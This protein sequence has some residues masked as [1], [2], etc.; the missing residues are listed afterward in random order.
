MRHRFGRALLALALT[1]TACIGCNDRNDGDVAVEDVAPGIRNARR[2]LQKNWDQ[3]LADLQK[4]QVHPQP[5]AHFFTL[6]SPGAGLVHREALQSFY[7][8]N[9]ANPIFTDGHGRPN[10]RARALIEQARDAERHALRPEKYIRPTLPRQIQQHDEL[11]Y[12]WAQIRTP[13]LSD[14]DWVVINA[15]LDDPEIRELERP[16]PE[17]LKRIFGQDGHEPAIPELAEAW[18]NRITLKRARDGSAALLELSLADAWLE[19]AYDMH[20]A[21]WVKVDDRARP[22]RQEEIR[23]E[24]LLA[25]MNDLANATNRADADA[26]MR[27]RLPRPQQYERLIEARRRFQNIVAEGDWEPIRPTT[28]ARGSSGPAVEALKVR[29]Q[30]EG[31]F[32]GTIDQRFDRDLEEAV[33]GYQETHQME[34]TGRSSNP[35][36]TSIN[37]SAANRLKQIE[38]TMQRWRETRIGD[39]EYYIFVNV[40]DFHAEVWRDGALE[41]RMRIVVG[42]ARRECRNDKLTYINATPSQ[43]ATMNHVILNP[44]WTVPQRI[45]NNDILPAFLENPAYFEERGYEQ[46]TAAN[47]HVMVRQLPGPQNALGMVKFM[48]PNEHDVYMHDT[49]QKVYFGSPTRA[50]SHGCIRVQNPL[51][52]LELLLVNDENW[53][54]RS[55]QR[56][57]ER[58]SEYRMNLLNPIPVYTEY[59]VVRVDDE[60]RVHFNADIYRLDRERL[61]MRFVREEDCTPPERA[62]RLRITSDGGLLQRNEE[63]ELVDARVLNAAPEDDLD[64]I[65]QDG[66]LPFIP[67]GLPPGLPADM[68]P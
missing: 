15:L 40:P 17:I 22:A 6:K 46:V 45:V 3:I 12:A 35:F 10:F 5:I 4:N 36:W 55:I 31:Y 18:K 21:Y 19:W 28:L 9:D 24:Q 7:A 38:L 32:H 30:K 56:I 60:G 47:G 49:P 20:D 8:N 64:A 54:E 48:F 1:L 11:Q 50:F 58:G 53:N 27:A 2:A 13:K 65:H 39:D 14:E 61:D 37:I 57:F 41:A 68:G 25:S 52:F 23:Q 43:T 59:Y 63:G 16:L 33:Q 66:V 67:I 26:V 51:D 42:N 62:P 29:L 34:A 44:Y